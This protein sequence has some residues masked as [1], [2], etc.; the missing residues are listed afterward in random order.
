M[1]DPPKLPRIKGSMHP[2]FEEILTPE[3]LAF[4][5]KLDGA[6]SGRRAELLAARRERGKRI[7]A[8]EAVDFLASTAN[9]RSDEW[10]VAPPAPGLEDR[11]AEITGPPTRK[12]SINALNSG[13]KVW[14][15]DFED[16]TSP[17]WTN[18]IDG[19]INLKDA[20]RG[21]LEF[22]S[23]DGKE[24]K[25]GDV[26]PTIVVRPRGWRL[27]EK[28]ISIDG[29]P[30]PAALVDFG[31]FFFHNAQ[32][33]IDNGAG[34][35]FYLPKLESHLEA[36]LW[37]DV[38]VQA[39]ALLGIPQGTIRATVLIETLPAAFEMEEILYELRDHS[40]GLNA[41]RWDY[42]F[43]Y[44]KTFAFRGDEYVLPDRS[45]ITM[46]TP[47]MRSYT[48]L[49]VST[50]HKR[51]AHAIGGMAAFVPNKANPTVTEQAL[52]KV[53]ADKEREAADGFDGSWVAHPGLV[54]TCIEAFT[55]VLG[56]RPNQLDKQRPDVHV[57]AADLLVRRQ[58]R[59]Q[60]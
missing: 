45:Q 35:Y 38:F 8:G 39:Q 33:L 19:Q 44:I 47:F 10:Q 53:K 12:M 20:I 54:P 18:V 40:S 41:G 21:Q 28:H 5:A 34:P 60:R 56:D 31:L 30:L 3:A 49:L 55:A 24:Y 59:R 11:R 22:T 23:E 4:V 25:V 13:A 48:E 50:C 17:S 52:A 9:I 51:G 42:I 37:N 16:A 1:F 57:T 26:T 43:S 27:C 7:S 2:R 15:A 29:R 46:T 14:M 6:H 58:R 36:R 32:Q